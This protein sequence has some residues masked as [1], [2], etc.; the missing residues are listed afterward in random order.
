[1]AM[2]ATSN[3]ITVQIC[4][5]FGGNGG[6]CGLGGGLVGGGRGGSGGGGEGGG[7]EGGGDGGGDGGGEG[8]STHVTVP[9]LDASVLLIQPPIG[10]A[11]A[12]NAEHHCPPEP[13]VGHTGSGMVM[14]VCWNPHCHSPVDTL[15]ASM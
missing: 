15:R 14:R 6:A 3:S 4:R 7:G 5:Q 8:T 9:V 2:T 1:M 12:L 11:E 13:E 10:H